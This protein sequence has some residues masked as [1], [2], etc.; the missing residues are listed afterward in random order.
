MA[1]TYTFNTREEAYD[2]ARFGNM[3]AYHAVVDA[4]ALQTVDSMTMAQVREC[5]SIHI[6]RHWR[7]LGHIAVLNPRLIEGTFPVTV[8]IPDYPFENIDKQE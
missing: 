7:S 6:A 4:L 2:E 3:A 5:L 1:T 8:T